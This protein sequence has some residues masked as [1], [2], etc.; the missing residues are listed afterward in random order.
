MKQTATITFVEG[1]P[2]AKI[3][4]SEACA[5]CGACKHGQQE[6]LLMSVPDGDYREGDEI[7]LTLPEGRLAFASIFAYGLPLIMLLIGTYIG[8]AA[9]KSDLGAAACAGA[10]LL[11]SIVGIRL[12]NGR[13]QKSAYLKPNCCPRTDEGMGK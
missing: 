7:E 9:F 11:V 2:M 12:M 13:L 1:V 8:Y 3:E 5:S 6:S 4:R 10:M